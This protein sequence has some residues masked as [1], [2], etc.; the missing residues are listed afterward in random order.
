MAALS[1]VTLFT[2]RRRK[3]APPGRH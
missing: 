2:V 1:H 3:M